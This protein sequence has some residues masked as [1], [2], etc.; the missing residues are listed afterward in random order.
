MLQ[1]AFH[2]TEA[3]DSVDMTEPL[4][5]MNGTDLYFAVPSAPV[6]RSGDIFSKIF[7]FGFSWASGSASYLQ[8]ENLTQSGVKL[9][10]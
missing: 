6:V 10:T 2:F 8:T 7:F 9:V 4:L 3:L 5:V 1:Q